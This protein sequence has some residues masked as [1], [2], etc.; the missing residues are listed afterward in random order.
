L[1]RYPSLDLRNDKRKSLYETDLLI[2]QQ[3]VAGGSGDYRR[4]SYHELSDIDRIDQQQQPHSGAAANNS[5]NFQHSGRK[6]AEPTPI[7]VHGHSH[8]HGH[9]G[10]VRNVYKQIPESHRYP[11]LDRDNAAAR[12]NPLAPLP[13]KAG[14]PAAF[15]HHHPRGGPL[16]FDRPA[17][18]RHSYA[19]PSPPGFSRGVTAAAAGGRFGLA[20]LK[21]Y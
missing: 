13:F 9:V 8:G 10:P 5:R 12:M 14:G 20:S 21:P 4:R 17:M 2:R 16:S 6:I 7:V 15:H 1:D 18:Y 3:L 19:D 11:G